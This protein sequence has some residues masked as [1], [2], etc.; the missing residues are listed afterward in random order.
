MD[1]IICNAQFSGLVERFF[2]CPESIITKCVKQT[3]KNNP[4][5]KT[6]VFVVEVDG[7]QYIVKRYNVTSI[8]HFLKICLRGTRGW[9]AWQFANL[10]KQHRIAAIFPVAFIEKRYGPLRGRAYMVYEYLDYPKGSEYVRS[11]KEDSENV[12]LLL[13]NT[14]RLIQQ[15][16]AVRLSHND[17]HLGNMLIHQDKPILFDLDHMRRHVNNKFFTKAHNSDIHLFKWYLRDRPQL[18]KLFMESLPS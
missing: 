6:S 16:K 12:R 14:V 18:I 5:E 3:I 10:L 8:K 15:L 11:L 13:A 7:K 2:K 17:F 1:K 9:R 4:H